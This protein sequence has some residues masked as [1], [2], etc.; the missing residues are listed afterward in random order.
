M[1]AFYNYSADMESDL[2][3]LEDK[4]G[5]LVQLYHAV[6]SENLQLRQELAQSR[7]ESRLLKEQMSKA[8]SRIEA[9]L[10]QLPEGS[11]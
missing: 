5:E 8:G 6:R 10:S 7:D 4:V 11:L 3:A 2:K 1:Q 9:L